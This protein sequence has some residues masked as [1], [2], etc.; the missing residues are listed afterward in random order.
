[1]SL[2][3]QYLD[4]VARTGPI[5]DRFPHLEGWRYTLFKDM[6]AKRRGASWQAAIKQW[7]RPWLR[8]DRTEGPFKPADVLIWLESRRSTMT[9]PLQQLYRELESRGVA[10]QLVAFNTTPPPG[11]S[12][13][14]FQSPAQARP[15]D[16]AGDAWNA[17]RSV[18]EGLDDPDLKRYFIYNCANTAGLLQE[19][20]RVLRAIRPKMVIMQ[21]TQQSGD[22][23]LV[24]AARALGITS[25]LLQHGILQPFYTPVTADTMITWGESSNQILADL[26]IDPA[27][28]IALGSPRHDA[29]QPTGGSSARQALH[30]ALSLPDKLTLAFFSN[31]NDLVRNGSAP[32]EIAVWLE[33]VAAQHQDDINVVVRLHPNEDGSLYANC[34]HLHITKQEVS[35]TTTLDGCDLVGSLCSTVLYE[36]L[37]YHKPVWQFY[38]D[39]WPDLADNWKTGLATRIESQADLS[40]QIEHALNEGTGSFFDVRMVERVFANQG[41][42]TQA[43]ADYIQSQLR[44]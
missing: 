32:Q 16:W 33:A 7:V 19:Q 11:L 21:T 8:R 43:I 22:A 38:A 28:L 5:F 34:P 14:R 37:L 6:V 15:P 9:E 30:E 25:L 39:G 42:A 12:A 10:V 4:F 29:M 3:E 1:M 23:A 31:G 17:L 35:L 40:R 2:D 20:D 41:R 44:Q 26:G 27:R 18:Y 24:V 36:G 13:L